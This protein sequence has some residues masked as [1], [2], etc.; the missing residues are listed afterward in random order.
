VQGNPADGQSDTM[1]M[2][3]KTAVAQKARRSQV[4]EARKIYDRLDSRAW[5]GSWTW[6]KWNWNRVP[7]ATEAAMYQDFKEGW[8]KSRLAREFR[9]NR[10]T[11]I[12]ICRD[13]EAAGQ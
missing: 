5:T 4:E 8:T 3:L 13:R 1:R 7:P 11:V 9:L 2:R 6:R 10:R 12:R